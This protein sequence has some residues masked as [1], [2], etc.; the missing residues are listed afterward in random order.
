MSLSNSGRIRPYTTKNYIFFRLF[1]TAIIGLTL[2]YLLKLNSIEWV[3]KEHTWWLLLSTVM[4]YIFTELS[5]FYIE[6]ST[7]Y[8]IDILKGIVFAW[9]FFVFM[10]GMS[11]I[12]P[13]EIIENKTYKSYLFI[14]V[15]IIP[16][17][18]I[19]FHALIHKGLNFIIKPKVKRV[20]II[21]ITRLGFELEK[22][23]TEKNLGF[24]FIGYFD[25]RLSNRDKV[26]IAPNAI[27]GDIE[28]LVEMTK[29]K[30]VD[31]IYITLA[32]QAEK[33]I[34]KVVQ[35]LSDTTASVYYAPDLF[36]FS[37]LSSQVHD[38]KGIPVISIYDTP[39]QGVNLFFKGIFDYFF[40]FFILILISPLLVAISIAIKM[41][42]EG[43]I[44]FKQKR[45]GFNGEEITVWK[46]RS[47]TVMEDGGVVTQATK[48]D[49]RVT[50]LGAILRRTS[51]DELP[52]F[53]NVLQGKM[54]VVGP[55]P[56]AV[57]HNQY[58]RKEVSRYM[59]RHKVKPGITGL[60]QIKGFRGETDTMDKM[61]GRIRF[62]LEYISSW[63]VW[64]DIKIIFFTIFK[65]FSGAKVY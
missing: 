62:D 11:Y 15:T 28:K 29:N 23:F 22:S 19:I 50:K 25:D 3:H 21:G 20:A 44:L 54:S 13:L 16:I 39:F 26:D 31:A 34:Q 57:A 52:Q 49:P 65:G 35:D 55:R 10:I 43:P 5:D 9:V 2:L 59:L 37:L 47:M 64:L 53:V 4:F 51:M 7:R 45:F 63:S 6:K 17:E 41:T 8:R 36:V 61:E 18:I 58:Y 12:T 60:A 30:E 32:L 42:S 48:N 38:F 46:F 24:K 27:I 56:H 33:R 14:W 40:S 1:D